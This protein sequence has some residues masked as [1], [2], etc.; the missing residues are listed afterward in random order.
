M[1]SRRRNSK[2]RKGLCAC[3]PVAALAL[4]AHAE[5]ST[6]GLPFIVPAPYDSKFFRPDP[7][8]TN[9]TYNADAQLN[10]YGGKYAGPSTTRPLLELGRELYREGPFQPAPDWAGKKNL[11][12]ADLLV[13]GDWRT[14]LAW[15]DAGK[16][17][18]GALNTRLDLDV[19]LKLTATERVHAFFRPLDKDGNFTGVHFGDGHQSAQLHLDGNPDALFFEGDAAAITTG[20]T[21]KNSRHDLPFAVGLIPLLFQ[22]GIWLNDAFTGFAFT[23]PARNSPL[24]DLSNF[25]VTFFAGFDQVSTPAF[26]SSG[27]PDDTHGKIFG[28]ASF[29]DAMQGYWELDY[30]YLDGDQNLKNES[31]HNFAAAFT[32]RYFNLISNSMRVIANV[33]QDTQPGGGHTANGVLLLMENSLVANEPGTLVPYCDLFVG[34]DHPQSAARDPGA[35]GPL[36]NTGILFESD[37][38][39]G[40]PTLDATANDT[41]GGALGVEYLFNFDQ[42]IVFEAATVQVMGSDNVAGRAA[43]G[44]EYGVGVRYQLPLSHSWILRADAMFGLLEASQNVAGIRTE[45][46]YKF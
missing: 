14:A 32:H 8:Y 22:N 46:R 39:T 43:K 28:V 41:W 26:V 45:L 37:A 34:V 31:Y 19:D 2:F 38:L 23:I 21:G 36:V 29:F 40:F 1:K 16:N 30:A 44:D 12:F 35:G 3:A 4:S 25:D 15:N 27:R 5:N 11:I 6:N 20:I 13:S 18:F 24:F 10:I 17:S 9:E 42:Q 33:G 7:S